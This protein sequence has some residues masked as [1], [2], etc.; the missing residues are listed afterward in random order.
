[1]N[2]EVTGMRYLL[3]IIGLVLCSSTW[4]QSKTEVICSYAPSQSSAVAAVSGAAGGS[5][6]TAG[7][8]AAATGLTAVTHSSGALI[9]TGSSGYIAG[10][11][12][13][14]A[15]TIAAAP[16]V[17]AVG[18]VVGGSAVTLELIC[19][20]KNHPEQV[21]KINEAASEFSK[22]FSDAMRKTTVAVGNLRK[23]VGPMAGEAQVRVK[24][25]TT[26]VWEYVYARIA[27]SVG[28]ST[29]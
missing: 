13:A 26:D 4:G 15:S 11:I 2:P 9:L 18:L 16:V 22:R 7:A 19:A 27:K 5:G 28:A 20:S 8:I 17:V 21:A 14:T 10:T 3:P 25:I 29:N 23:T 1:M 12:G 24:T 6:A